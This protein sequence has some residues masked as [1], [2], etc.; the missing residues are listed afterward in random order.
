M[1]Y[2]YLVYIRIRETIMS[3]YKSPVEE[4][5]EELENL[6][7]SYPEFDSQIHEAIEQLEEE[8]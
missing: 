7:E 3:V 6:A 5:I 1:S 4:L 8:K 2:R